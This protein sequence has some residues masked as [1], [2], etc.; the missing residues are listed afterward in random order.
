MDKSSMTKEQW[1]VIALNSHNT[2]LLDLWVNQA[3]EF[4]TNDKEFMKTVF[5]EAHQNSK[6]LN[7]TQIKELM[8]S[9]L[10]DDEDF[11]IS[12][13]EIDSD[14][15]KYA[16]DRLLNSSELDIHAIDRLHKS[17]G[18][19]S[20]LDYM[21]EIVQNNSNVFMHIIK[22]DQLF[23]DPYSYTNLL[24]YIGQDLAKDQEFILTFAKKAFEVREDE[25]KNPYT[26]DYKRWN[27]NNWNYDKISPDLLSNSEFA[28]KLVSAD[29]Y[30]YHFI[31]FELRNNDLDI[32]RIA[33][34]KDPRS[35]V[36][37]NQ[38]IFRDKDTALEMVSNYPALFSSLPRRLKADRD[39]VMAVISS[40][41]YGLDKFRIEE[42]ELD[43]SL[44]CDK[45]VMLAFLK[46]DP[47]TRRPN[48][49]II[50]KVSY[51]LTNDPE[52][53]YETGD[54]LNGNRSVMSDELRNAIVDIDNEE[55]VKQCLQSMIR[56][57]NL[58]NALPEKPISMAKQLSLDIQNQNYD[59]GSKTTKS[60]KIKL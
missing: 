29:P 13:M 53:I 52:F 40:E 6:T 8:P 12:C 32:S 22:N 16:S 21:G 49:N 42:N 47:E 14:L 43:A 45:E 60:A 44:L 57:N 31:N 3:P 25:P 36:M 50:H 15:V 28:K 1:R 59:Y 24:D 5:L 19:I 4:I 38:D 37:I 41:K 26:A 55:H 51:S 33:Y 39:I 27:N 30:S 7:E 18:G 23:S 9:K 2:T 20:F 35:S 48:P 46:K 58:E 34:E 54:Y 56:K 11:I 17:N 10:L